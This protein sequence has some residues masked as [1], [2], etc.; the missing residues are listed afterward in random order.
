MTKTPIRYYDVDPWKIC[1]TGFDPGRSLVSESVFSIANEYMGSRGF[2]EEGYGGRTLRGNYL[3][4][5][6]EEVPVEHAFGNEFQGLV[7]RSHFMVNCPDWW[8]TR[9]AANGTPLDLAVSE[10]KGFR[11]ELDFKTGMMTRSFDWLVDKS[12]TVRITFRRLMDMVEPR[13]AYQEIEIA[14]AQG[15]VEVGF[16]VGVDCEVV[17][18]TH[19]KR[20]WNTTFANGDDRSVQVGAILPESKHQLYVNAE[21][22]WDVTGGDGSESGS[23]QR[24]LPSGVRTVGS[25]VTLGRGMQLRIVRRV[26]ILSDRT[27]RGHTDEFLSESQRESASGDR[28]PI[29]ISA[30]IESQRRYWESFWKDS[31]IR[32]EGD[33]AAQQGIR[34][35][36]FQ[37]HAS[38]RG[39]DPTVNVTA[40]GLTGEAYSGWYWWDTETYCLPFY[41][42][43]DPK[44]A[45]SLLQYRY[46]TL[47]QARDRAREMGFSGARYPMTTINGSEACGV[48]Q[49]CD[50][51]IHV[52]GAVGYGIWHYVHVTKDK[53]FLKR[54]GLEMLIEICRFYASR[55]AYAQV[56]GDYGFYGIMG[57][58]EFAMMVNNNFYTNY[59]AKWLFQY[60]LIELEDLMTADPSAYRGLVANTN[61]SSAEMDDWR[62]KAEKM[63]IRQR[64]TD[65]VFEQHDGYFDLPHPDVAA[66]PPEDFPLYKS[67][68]YLKIFSNDMIKQPD[69][70]LT[71]F[72]FSSRFPGDVKRAN[73][74]Y[75]EPRCVH[76]SSLSPGIHGI[77]A[78]ELGRTDTAVRFLGS[79]SRLDLDDYNRNTADG[80]HVTSM[81]A[82]WLAAVYGVAGL[83]SDGDMVSLDPVLPPTW[84]LVELQLQ[85]GRTRLSITIRKDCTTVTR[86]SGPPTP[87]RMA[88][89]TQRVETSITVPLAPAAR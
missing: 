49:H 7:R 68:P 74:D 31:D 1:E 16:Q 21:F 47:P 75:Y 61:L 35:C 14:V 45:R 3:N 54:E 17:Q 5:L 34:F 76:E 46:L 77:L 26:Q 70:L 25:T 55:G 71:I 78:L 52:P 44:V 39:L 8:Y 11:R 18:E 64:E 15:R 29:D 30:A 33:A 23:D 84:N 24:S 43:T 87:I 38:Y 32:I 89:I 88:G 10:T 48:W 58:D 63:R 40:K 37:I 81:F 82:A 20:Y 51:E 27:G 50:L 53:E 22:R 41:L 85:Y 65:A 72:L 80:L 42:F 36:L 66:I 83:R 4:G 86:I 2:F 13:Y 9:L 56:S 12:T 28:R 62:E 73:Y 19:R 57:P 79:A 69:V 67:W 60:T 6:Y 59:L